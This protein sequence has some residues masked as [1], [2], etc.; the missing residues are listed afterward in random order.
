MIGVTG[1]VGGVL[2]IIF[3]IVIIARPKIV[4]WLVG[5]YFIILGVLAIIGSVV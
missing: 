3:G 5:I 1:I 4:A 2:A